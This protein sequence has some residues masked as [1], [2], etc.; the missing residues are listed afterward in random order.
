MENNLIFFS[1]VCL[2]RSRRSPCTIVENQVHGVPRDLALGK[3]NLAGGIAATIGNAH[4]LDDMIIGH[5]II[6]GNTVHEFGGVTY[7]HDI[8][9]G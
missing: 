9:T 3:K 4:A 7:N 6:A 8:F 5:S 1:T 2:Q